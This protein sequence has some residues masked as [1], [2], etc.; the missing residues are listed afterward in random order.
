[1]VT[2]HPEWFSE[3]FTL[4]VWEEFVSQIDPDGDGDDPVD[5]A[6]ELAV[7]NVQS[8]KEGQPRPE[9]HNHEQG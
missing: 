2:E 5:D 7:G 9:D 3:D 8:E 1:M 4:D 6:I